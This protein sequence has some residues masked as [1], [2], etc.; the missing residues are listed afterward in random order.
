MVSLRVRLAAI[1]MNR[2]ILFLDF[3]GMQSPAECHTEWFVNN[4]TRPV[5]K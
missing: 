5:Q 4:K 3:V 2:L 1:P